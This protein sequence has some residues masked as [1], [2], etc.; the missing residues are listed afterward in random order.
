MDNYWLNKKNENKFKKDLKALNDE[1]TIENCNLKEKLRTLEA[2]YDK[3]LEE[4]F[5]QLHGELMEAERT[6]EEGYQE[7][8]EIICDLR[9]QLEE[10]RKGTPSITTFPPSNTISPSVKITDKDLSFKEPGKDQIHVDVYNA[11]VLSLYNDYEKKAKQ[12]KDYII[13]KVDQFLKMEAEERDNLLAAHLR[14]NYTPKQIV[15]TA[16]EQ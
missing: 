14:A 4:A 8:Y 7:A 9:K 6:A 11:A 3:K 13:E 2:E 12:Q 1:L 16:L 10:A 15:D 5:E